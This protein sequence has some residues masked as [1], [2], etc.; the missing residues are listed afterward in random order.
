MLNNSTAGLI[1]LNLV[2]AQKVLK[3]GSYVNAMNDYS[4][5]NFWGEPREGQTLQEV[6]DLLLG[7]ID[8]IKK[9]DFEDW[10]VPAII[11]DFKKMKMEQLESN[12]SRANDMVMAFTNDM[13]WV[14]Y[15]SLVQDMEKITKTEDC[16][17]STPVRW[18]M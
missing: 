5:H 18:C 17:H 6:R 4:I 16:T 3:A 12:Y 13:P 11:N 1:D 15:V 9:G 10:L 8:K 7:E 2:Q 14:E